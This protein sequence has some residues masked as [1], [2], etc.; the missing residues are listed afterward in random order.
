MSAPTDF[1]A[2]LL[3]AR[4]AR[5]DDPSRAHALQEQYHA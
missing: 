1:T 2:S 4:Q 5:K 3:S